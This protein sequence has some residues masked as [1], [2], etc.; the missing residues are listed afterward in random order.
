MISR[1][2]HFLLLLSSN[3]FD[4]ERD[5]PQL[6]NLLQ[7]LQNNNGHVANQLGKLIKKTILRTE[8]IYVW[9]AFLQRNPLLKDI[10]QLKKQAA[11]FNKKAENFT[12]LF[13]RK[14]KTKKYMLCFKLEEK[15]KSNKILPKKNFRDIHEEYEEPKEIEIMQELKKALETKEKEV[16]ELTKEVQKYKEESL[17]ITRELNSLKYVKAQLVREIEELKDAVKQHKVFKYTSHQALRIRTPPAEEEVQKQI[18][19]WSRF[20]E[21]DSCAIDLGSELEIARQLLLITPQSKSCINTEMHSFELSALQSEEYATD[22]PNNTEETTRIDFDSEQQQLLANVQ[23]CKEH[24]QALNTQV[25]TLHNGNDEIL[26]NRLE[27][28]DWNKELQQQINILKQK[29]QQQMYEHVTAIKV[30]KCQTKKKTFSD[31]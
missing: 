31:Y 14:L 3:E 19:R 27:L 1:V 13:L 29:S 30:V 20:N 16:F 6:F 25:D 10:K 11:G 26:K 9:I 12:T 18:K 5:K 2:T 15:K 21:A 7:H 24:I 8:Y 4:P 22:R 17:E 28:S 23:K